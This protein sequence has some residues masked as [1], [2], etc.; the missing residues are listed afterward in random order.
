LSDEPEVTWLV[1]VHATRRFQIQL[2][3]CC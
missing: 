2:L 3:H 1:Q